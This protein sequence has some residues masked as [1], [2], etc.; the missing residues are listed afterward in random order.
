M[1]KFKEGQRVKLL[2]THVLAKE[3]RKRKTAIYSGKDYSGLAIIKF[4]KATQY[5]DCDYIK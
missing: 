1:K 4:G 5:I 3:F 2:K